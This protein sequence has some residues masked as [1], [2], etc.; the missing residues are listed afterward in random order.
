MQD[1]RIERNGK[2]WRK[3]RGEDRR[4]RSMEEEEDWKRMKD[5]VRRGLEEDE[6][7]SKKRTGRGWRM[8]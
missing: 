3:E 5:G 2:G 1:W 6:G 7:W 8:E 4:G